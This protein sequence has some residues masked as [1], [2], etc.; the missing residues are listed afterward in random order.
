MAPTVC[1]NPSA[2]A[3]SACTPQNYGQNQLSM[4]EALQP[5]VTC[6]ATQ[7]TVTANYLSNAP[8]SIFGQNGAILVTDPTTGKT[9][10]VPLSVIV[11]GQ[12]AFADTSIPLWCSQL[13]GVRNQVIRVTQANANQYSLPSEIDVAIN[14]LTLKGSFTFGPVPLQNNGASNVALLCNAASLKSSLS[15]MTGAPSN[16]VTVT[17]G[18]NG[19]MEVDLDYSGAK[20]ASKWLGNPNNIISDTGTLNV[21]L[22]STGSAYG[23]SSTQFA[24]NVAVKGDTISPAGVLLTFWKK[25]TPPSVG[26]SAAATA[27]ASLNAAIGEDTTNILDGEETGTPISFTGVSLPTTISNS[28]TLNVPGLPAGQGSI[29]AANSQLS[30]VGLKLPSTNSVSSYQGT[31]TI[32][33]GDSKEILPV[34]S[35]L[36]PNPMVV[37]VGGG[38][39]SSNGQVSREFYF[40]GPNKAALPA[41]VTVQCVVNDQNTANPSANQL[42]SN[43]AA[44]CG[45]NKGILFTETNSGGASTLPFINQQGSIILTFSGSLA[46]NMAPITI[47]VYVLGSQAESQD[48]QNLAN[49][50]SYAQSGGLYAQLVAGTAT[51]TAQ[52]T[53]TGSTTAFGSQASPNQIVVGTSF[54]GRVVFPQGDPA[55]T[56]QISILYYSQTQK[57]WLPY[58]EP[59]LSFKG[60]KGRSSTCGQVCQ[61]TFTPGVAQPYELVAQDAGGK[62][63]A[64]IYYAITTPDQVQIAPFSNNQLAIGAP[65]TTQ[66]LWSSSDNVNQRTVAIQQ[67]G[68]VQGSYVSTFAT[69]T[70]VTGA[71]GALSSCFS[72]AGGHT[73]TSVQISTSKS[74]SIQVTCDPVLGVLDYTIPYV[75]GTYYLQI[76]SSTSMKVPAVMF[77]IGANGNSGGTNLGAGQP[78]C[79]GIGYVGPGC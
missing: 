60:A 72:Q 21:Q 57:S 3:L 37:P 30:F 1:G 54:T 50:L 33:S 11:L 7:L 47:P 23:G 41:G 43:A 44:T 68:K 25:E 62:T 34:Y 75:K 61:F 45:D 51:M 29:T 6:S 8:V 36:I 38:S 14:P 19:N 69:A 77:T 2:C 5:Q 22:G 48:A 49:E 27:S 65:I 70:T 55:S 15:Q 76:T 18:N 73:V 12:N 42:A 64:D 52:A 17:C 13:G 32:A 79:Q 53:S 16:A 20:V 4:S 39:G 66:I 35:M 24:I 71:V 67:Q 26:A 28:Y 56:N 74:N 9:A 63:F 46:S 58:K 59:T 31:L 10:T 40:E 78:K